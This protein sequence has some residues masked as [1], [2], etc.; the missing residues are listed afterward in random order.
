MYYHQI[1][2]NA[3]LKAML[4]AW[5]QR[6]CVESPENMSRILADE[7]APD[8]GKLFAAENAKPVFR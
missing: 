1:F 3:G 4:K 2:F 5:L 7:Y 8:K 6:D